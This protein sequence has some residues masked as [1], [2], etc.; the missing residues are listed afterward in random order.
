[1]KIGYFAHG[2]WAHRALKRILADQT[3]EV[4]FVATRNVGDPTLEAIAAESNLP[5]FV[6]GRVNEDAELARLG[7]F[8]AELFVSMSFD[9]IFGRRLLTLPPKGVINCHAGALPFYRGRN[10]LNW[11]LINGENRFGVTVHYMDEGI[12]TGPILQ[13]DFVSIGPDECYGDLLEKAY[14]QCAE[15]LHKALVRLR[16]GVVPIPQ[17]TI[18]PV[19]F[20]CGQRR[21]GDEWLDWRGSSAEIHDF[22]RGIGL[23]GPCAR[24]RM[25]DQLVAIVR[26]ERIPGAISYRGTPGEVVG[27]GPNGVVVKTGDSVLRVLQ[28]AVVGPDGQLGPV[29]IASLPIGSRFCP[30][31]DYRIEQLEYRVRELEALVKLGAKQDEGMA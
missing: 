22:V 21:P 15:S 10:I 6:P 19:G 12:D 17:E 24:S 28:T 29:G 20:Y 26:T 11:A 13:Q 2:P 30:W 14:S 5:F 23:P 3:F 8:G 1:M 31:T 18:D 7:S 27:R 16:E 25:G 4:C 9:Q